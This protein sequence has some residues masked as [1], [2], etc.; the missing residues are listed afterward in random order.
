LATDKCFDLVENKETGEKVR[1]STTYFEIA[2]D[3]QA[4]KIGCTIHGG[5]TPGARSLIT[6]SPNGGSGTQQWPRAEAV[7]DV[8]A[9]PVI[10]LK[11]PTVLGVDPYNS[12]QAV[13]NVQDMRQFAGKVAPVESAAKAPKPTDAP[14]EPEV[15][16]AVIVTPGEKNNNPADS[17]IK[18]DP[19]PPLEF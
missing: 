4:P 6:G 16:R 2:T 10:T 1:R 9:H 5:P 19:P 13:A 8:N 12:L 11:G 3:A 15:R 18:L 17:P 7:I 14:P